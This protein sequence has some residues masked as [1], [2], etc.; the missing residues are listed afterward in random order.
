MTFQH[1][2]FGLAGNTWIQLFRY[3]LVGGV[4]F[5]VDFS[6][7]VFLTE[8]AETH[9]LASAAAGFL[10]GLGTNYVLSVSWVF[11]RRRLSSR[12]LEFALFAAIGLVG[13]AMNEAF[14]YGFTEWV[15][16]HYIYSKLATAILVYL[17]NFGARKL[18][19]FR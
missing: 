11:N 2:I 14:I 3:T 7:L 12:R 5:A 4:A 18:S 19:L 15:G 1:L 13:L 17:W 9:Y 16:M 8:M 10:A 6:T